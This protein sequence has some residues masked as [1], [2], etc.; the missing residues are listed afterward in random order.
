MAVD[1]AVEAVNSGER[2]SELVRFS[3]SFLC[4]LPPAAVAFVVAADHQRAMLKSP[5]PGPVAAVA[6][7]QAPSAQ[8]AVSHFRCQSIGQ[9]L[10]GHQ[11]WPW[12]AVPSTDGGGD[13]AAAAFGLSIPGG[14]VVWLVHRSVGS[15]IHLA[16]C[17]ARSPFHCSSPGSD[18]VPWD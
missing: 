12:L 10:A 9:S 18:C 2:T 16:A 5:S 11:S 6:M 17:S 13:V 7:L 4:A 3:V 1:L 15:Q 14:G 8:I